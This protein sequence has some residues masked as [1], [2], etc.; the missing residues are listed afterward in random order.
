MGFHRIARSIPLL[1]FLFSCCAKASAD[2]ITIGQL[3]YLGTENGVSGYKVTLDTDGV[4]LEPLLF[5]NISLSV[6]GVSQ[7]TSTITTP[8]VL[9][10]TG[11]I[12]RVLPAC[13]CKSILLKLDFFSSQPQVSFTLA[14]GRS[15][16][17]RALARSNLHASEGFLKPGDETPIVLIS[18]P[19]PTTWLLLSTGLLC[20]WMPVPTF[21]SEVLV[22]ARRIH[23]LFWPRP[24]GRRHSPLY[25]A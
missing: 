21:V 3:Q 6:K 10:F 4:T 11:G 20:F 15:F 8:T 23:G 13:P 7:Q 2:S 1:L 14:D 16:T 24:R 5:E 12:E 22:F 18:V 19:E 25:R 9:L 17:T